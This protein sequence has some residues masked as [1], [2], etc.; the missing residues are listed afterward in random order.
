MELGVKENGR[1]CLKLTIHLAGFFQKSM[2]D[3]V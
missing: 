2:N 1:V 3:G